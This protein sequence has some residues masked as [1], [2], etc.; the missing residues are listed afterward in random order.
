[1]ARALPAAAATDEEPVEVLLE[2][3]VADDQRR[4]MVR[5]YRLDEDDCTGHLLLVQSADRAAAGNTSLRSAARDRALNSVY[6]DLAHDMKGAL[7]AMVLN[8]ELLR[9]SIDSAPG[10][11]ARVL[12]HRCTAVIGKETERLSRALST[13]LH[14]PAHSLLGPSRVD[15]SSLVCGV[16]DLVKARCD[17]QHVELV[18]EPGAGVAVEGQ[19]EQIH[20]ALLNLV[21]N[22]LE[23][24]PGGGR[25]TMSVVPGAAVA[26][27][28]VSDTGPGIPA[29][30]EKRIWRLHATTK[31]GG[32]GIGLHVTRSIV[33]S[34]AGTIRYERT[35][36]GVTCFIMELPAARN[37]GA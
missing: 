5:A 12:Q 1:V 25:L 3:G 16:G 15:L 28:S 6:R 7:N 36:E 17:R 11:A 8:V 2:L 18:V 34:H 24:M 4:F 35:P 26:R 31:P 9:Q 14:G 23:A 20:V 10:E 30:W 22:A 37:E 29:G 33:R 32:T 21:V 27:L 13:L 19:A